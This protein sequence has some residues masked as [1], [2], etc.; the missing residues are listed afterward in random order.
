MRTCVAFVNYTWNTDGK[1]EASVGSIQERCRPVT[2]LS[3]S[4]SES[5]PDLLLKEIF[6]ALDDQKGKHADI[7]LQISRMRSGLG[8]LWVSSQPKQSHPEGGDSAQGKIVVYYN[9][10]VNYHGVR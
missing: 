1:G 7:F 6:K 5:N 3:A 2:F 4:K 8:S 10:H 9:I